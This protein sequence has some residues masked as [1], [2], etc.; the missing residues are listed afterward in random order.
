L[1]SRRVKKGPGRRPQSAKRQLKELHN[2]GGASWPPLV[3]SAFPEPRGTTGR[4]VTRP[5][6]AVR[7]LG[8]CLR[9][10]G[11][12]CVR[13]VEGCYRRTSGSRSPICG[14]ARVAPQRDR[15]SGLPSVRCPPSRDRA[16]D[17]QSSAAHGGQRQTEA[18]GR[19]ASDPKV[20]PTADQPSFAV[21]VPCAV[22]DVAVSREHLPGRLSAG[23]GI[24][25]AIAAGFASSLTAAHRARSPARSSAHRT[26]SGKV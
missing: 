12:Q 2:E 25:A 22:G 17:P 9:W 7:L 13:S 11:W 19:G 10:S 8:L 1:S 5:I 18:V 16:S 3:R 15:E 23:I 24:A 26:A 14:L 20:E 4:V 21:E 6:D